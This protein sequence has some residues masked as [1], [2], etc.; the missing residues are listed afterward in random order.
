LSHP[1][2]DEALDEADH[3][4]AAIGRGRGQQGAGLARIALGEGQPGQMGLCEGGLGRARVT[5]Q[6][7]LERGA[8]SGRLGQIHA[9]HR[10]VERGDLV[11]AGAFGTATGWS[12]GLTRSSRRD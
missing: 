10:G 9:G 2:L 1:R 6:E 12:F 7:A 3:A 11:G 5:G 4:L 8:A